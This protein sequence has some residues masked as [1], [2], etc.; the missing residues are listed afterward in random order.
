VTGRSA[1]KS[2]GLHWTVVPSE[3]KKK[4]QFW[5]KEAILF[6]SVK[7]DFLLLHDSKQWIDL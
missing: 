7:A 2:E 5:H 1:L 6:T 3:K 4:K